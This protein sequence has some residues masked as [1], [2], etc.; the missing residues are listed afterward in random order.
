VRVQ[1]LGVI[2]PRDILL[3]TSAECSFVSAHDRGVSATEDALTKTR[4][5]LAALAKRRQM[6]PEFL[7]SHDLPSQYLPRSRARDSI[8]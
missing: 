8:F 6:S 1:S 7:V 2:R 3:L 4:R 5:D